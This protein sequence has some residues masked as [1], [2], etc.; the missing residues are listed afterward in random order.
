M[1]RARPEPRWLTIVRNPSD[2]YVNIHTTA[3]RSG[4]IRGQLER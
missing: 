2:Y 4:E 3:V 1:R